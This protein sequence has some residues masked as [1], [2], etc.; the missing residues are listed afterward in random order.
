MKNDEEQCITTATPTTP[1]TQT[2][3]TTPTSELC[4]FYQHTNDLVTLPF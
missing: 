4:T 2:T 1:T 3:P